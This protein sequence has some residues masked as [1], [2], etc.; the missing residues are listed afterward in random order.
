[1]RRQSCTSIAAIVAFT[2]LAGCTTTTLVPAASVRVPIE[3]RGCA[4]DCRT[5]MPTDLFECFTHCPGA[6]TQLGTGCEH[7]TPVCATR[8]REVKTPTGLWKVLA[9]VGAIV[10]VIY[11]ISSRPSSG[12]GD[13]D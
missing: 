10:F 8:F 5:L 11:T 2:M 12:G 4:D 1:V 6:E 3:E 13:G 9:V 7:E